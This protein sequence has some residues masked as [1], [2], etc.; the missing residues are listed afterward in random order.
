MSLISNKSSTGELSQ[1]NISAKTIG[2]LQSLADHEPDVD[3]IFRQIMKTPFDFDRCNRRTDSILI[4][5]C[6]RFTPFNAQVNI[7]SIYY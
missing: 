2:V 7:A 5:P 1:I 6:G 4:L 3:A